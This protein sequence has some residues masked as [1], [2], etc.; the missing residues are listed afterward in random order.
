[1]IFNKKI[2]IDECIEKII[3]GKFEEVINDEKLKQKFESVVR[4]AQ[5]K[6]EDREEIRT[7]L[8]DI[9]YIAGRISSFKL[10]LYHES[11]KIEESTSLLKNISST[12]T[13]D[14]DTLSKNQNEISS[15]CT[16]MAMSLQSM[17][18]KVCDIEESTVKNSENILNIENDINQIHMQ[19]KAIVDNV[20]HLIKTS[21]KVTD[22]MLQIDKISEQTNLLALNAS[23][24]AARS[25]EAGKGFAVVAEEIRKLSDDTKN[26]L[27]NINSLINDM[28]KYSTHSENSIKMTNKNINSIKNLIKDINRDFSKDKENIIQ[29]SNEMSQISAYSQQFAA[30]NQEITYSIDETKEVAIAIADVSYNLNNV[31]HNI[32]DTIKGLDKIEQ[33]SQNLT[34]ISKNLAKN[35][36]YY[37]SN[38]N[39]IN[40]FEDAIKAHSNWMNI[41]EE[42]YNTMK[43]LPIQTND[44][45]CHFGHFYFN[46][47]PSHK[48]ITPI[49]S[50]IDNLHNELHNVGEDMINCIKDN[51]NKNAKEYLYKAKNNSTKLFELFDIIISKTKEIDKNNQNVFL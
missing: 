6:I 21:K 9:F 18:D 25:G 35:P 17:E 36:N 12:M 46:L 44:K 27:E 45:K 14:L 26:L 10:E 33:A 16:D 43:I 15:A 22:S 11:D 29:I 47:T 20:D 1:M 34:D 50:Q 48:E 3:E 37:M 19:S 30:S 5:N 13:K 24:E 8:N 41:L 7:L 2:N 39:F 32:N 4:L 38:E 49:W 51:D 40:I 42:M 28:S 31:T 23:I